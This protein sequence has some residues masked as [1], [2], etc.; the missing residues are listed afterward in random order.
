MLEE[1]KDTFHINI[2]M[3]RELL[4][5]M[6]EVSKKHRRSMHSQILWTLEQ[7]IRA[8][9]EQAEAQRAE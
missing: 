2:K 6:R 5:D 3:T 1:N 7:F 4:E 9:K 8:E